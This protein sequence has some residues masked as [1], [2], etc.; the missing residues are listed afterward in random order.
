MVGCA[1]SGELVVTP[2]Q[3]DLGLVGVGQVA[4]AQ[5]AFSNPG[6]SDVHLTDVSLSGANP[7]SFQV[8]L[9][10][11]TTI[12]AGSS[13]SVKVAFRPAWRG[14]HRAVLVAYSDARNLP[15]LAFDL[16]GESTAVACLSVSCNTPPARFCV[17]GVTSR[18]YF[19][20]GTC[21]DDGS[22]AYQPFDDRCPVACID[23]ENGCASHCPAGQTQCGLSCFDSHDPSHCGPGCQVC[24]TLGDGL[25]SCDGTNCGMSCNA[26]ATNCGGTCVR[27]SAGPEV[28]STECIGPMCRA[29]C[30]AGYH[31]C[32]AGCCSNW[33]V[34]VVDA[35]SAGEGKGLAIALERNLVPKIAY[36]VSGTPDE[37]W[38][39]FPPLRPATPWR[40]EKAGTVAE[41]TGR[42]IGVFA[43]SSNICAY[44]RTAGVL[45]LFAKD[46]RQ[47]GWTSKV[48]DYSANTGEYL[49]LRELT[50]SSLV[51]HVIAF[52]AAN[53][54][55]RHL[56]W[57]QGPTSS[58]LVD[59]GNALGPLAMALDSKGDL[60]VAYYATGHVLR[61]ASQEAGVWSIETVDSAGDVGSF[62]G[63]ALDS[64]DSPHLAYFDATNGAMKYAHL[65][66]GS[67]NVET[68]TA[69]A[70]AVE[71][72]FASIALDLWN[73]PH[74][75]WR[76]TPE[77][78]LRYARKTAS[79]WDLQ[80]I[81]ASGDAGSYASIAVDFTGQVHV[82]Y[83]AS[84]AGSG[85]FEL[86]YAK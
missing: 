47:G 56:W 35:A 6:G 86:R 38:L 76:R 12:A 55:L 74:L 4:E 40:T 25:P 65:S 71:G 21:L 28:V 36:F 24:Q 60:H 37:I 43:Q 50:G 85:R 84:P 70:G 81:D 30:G 5:V 2:S 53:A 58:E 80:T 64:A 29:R 19:A 17:D 57:S 20:S 45:R 31:S 26:G 78:W 11:G 13:V 39:A 27:C 79:G 77:G 42:G 59:S 69:T 63:L 18:R 48:I 73:E 44:D 75:V 23:A 82:A 68:V 1:R 46:Y 14:I 3:L 32:E 41:G 54:A 16:S 10:P 22:C 61:Y 8:D 67:W 15:V 62:V 72:T 52:D 7:D 34:D 33:T 83:A 9:T 51:D 49:G 66:G